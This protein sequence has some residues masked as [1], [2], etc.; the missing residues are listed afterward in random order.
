MTIKN[1]K[2]RL[3]YHVRKK[4]CKDFQNENCVG[5]LNQCWCDVIQLI[6]K[7][8]AWIFFHIAIAKNIARFFVDL[9]ELSQGISHKYRQNI[10]FFSRFHQK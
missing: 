6:K 5:R 8:I 7:C 2:A 3:E 10:M 1:E 9:T 4:D